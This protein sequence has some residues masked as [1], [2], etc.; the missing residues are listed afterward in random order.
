MAALAPYT[1]LARRGL[2]GPLRATKVE[3]MT[4]MPQRS[5]TYGFSMIFATRSRPNNETHNVFVEKVRSEEIVETSDQHFK[6]DE[7]RSFGD[8]K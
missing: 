3:P 8:E 5:G 4:N 6:N 7:F 1:P 2:I